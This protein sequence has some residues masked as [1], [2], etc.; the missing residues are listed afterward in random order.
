[1]LYR[2]FFSNSSHTSKVSSRSIS[3]WF[4]TL[5]S[6]KENLSK[7]CTH[8]VTI[9]TIGLAHPQVAV[10]DSLHNAASTPVD[11]HKKIIAL[12][13]LVAKKE[14][15]PV[16]CVC[17]MPDVQLQMIECTKC[18]CWF[19]VTCQSVPEEVKDNTDAAWLCS[20]VE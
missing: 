9:S 16:H 11:P 14:S 18:E 7:Y 1:M 2:G 6:L 8:W 19:H 13:T 20:K 4:T 17:R 15:L 3:A 12:S 10:F 5:K